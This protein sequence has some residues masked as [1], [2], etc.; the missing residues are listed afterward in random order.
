MFGDH[1]DRI[2]LPLTRTGGGV[3]FTLSE[4]AC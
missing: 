4:C 1:F 2:G 3:P